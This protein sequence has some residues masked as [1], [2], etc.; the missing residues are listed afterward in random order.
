MPASPHTPTGGETRKRGR[1]ERAAQRDPVGDQIPTTTTS[2]CSFSEVLEIS[3]QRF[4]DGGT[5]R[6]EC[7]DCH[8]LRAITPHNGIL[9]YPRHDRRKTQMPQT[10]PRWAQGEAGWEPVSGA[11]K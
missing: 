3:T 4:L 5:E 11:K 10:E 9:R 6:V 7:P 2:K 1:I 8:A